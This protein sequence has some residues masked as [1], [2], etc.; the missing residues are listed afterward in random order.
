[1]TVTKSD[2]IL[3]GIMLFFNLL[4]IPFVF[5]LQEEGTEVVVE[6]DNHLVGKYSLYNYVQFTS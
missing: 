2:K 5:A 6:V 3:I 1:M 4:S